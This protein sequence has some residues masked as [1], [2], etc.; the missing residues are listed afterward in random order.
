MKTRVEFKS[1]AFPKYEN[2]DE[3]IVNTNRWGKR[4]AEFVRDHLPQYGVET[5]NVLCEDWGWLV[6]TKSD[7]FPVWIG[8]GPMDDFEEEGTHESGTQTEFC[9]F[10][11]A[12]PGFFKKL[13]KKVDTKPAVS[14]VVAAIRRMIEDRPEFESVEWCE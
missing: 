6:Y 4:L 14:K 1:S 5:E 9:M 12:E 10:V 7:E 2:E 13:F 3:E 11:E 8:C